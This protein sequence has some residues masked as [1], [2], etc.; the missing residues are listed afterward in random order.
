VSDEFTVPLCRIHHRALHRT[1]DEAAWW[2]AEGIDPIKVA[3]KLWRNTRLGEQKR[4]RAAP[5]AEPPQAKMLAQ[6]GNRAAGS[7]SD[8]DVAAPAGRGS[9]L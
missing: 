5:P 6:Q 3:R 2:K 4:T 7:K 1:G 9:T 8:A